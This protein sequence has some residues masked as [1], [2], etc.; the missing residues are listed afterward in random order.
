MSDKDVTALYQSWCSAFQTLDAPRMKSL[1][2][3]S[4]DGLI[5]QPEEAPDPMFTWDEI[6]KYWDAIPLVVESI[7]EW[8][9]LRSRVSVDGDSAL[10]YLKLQ[11]HIELIG[12]KQ[13]LIGQ[14]RVTLGAHKTDDYWKLIKVH[15]SRHVDLSDLF[16]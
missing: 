6:D 7:P 8:R 15:E 9:E 5:Y 14:L 16:E 12:A 11:T 1:F 2:D 3:Q 13:P 4:F 10:V